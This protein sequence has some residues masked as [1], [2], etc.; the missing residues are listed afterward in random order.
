MQNQHATIV[1]KFAKYLST[2]EISSCSVSLPGLEGRLVISEIINEGI[3]WS[4]CGH[5]AVLSKCLL[6]YKCCIS[7]V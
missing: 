4:I 7:A 5:P 3:S 2:T 6:L 1:V